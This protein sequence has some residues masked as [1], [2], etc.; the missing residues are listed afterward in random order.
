VRVRISFVW[1]PGAGC[2]STWMHSER[3][4]QLANGSGAVAGSSACTLFSSKDWRVGEGAM[5][6]ARKQ[7][8]SMSVDDYHWRYLYDAAAHGFPDVRSEGKAIAHEQRERPGGLHAL[9]VPTDHILSTA[10]WV[11]RTV[12][13][14]AE[15]AAEDRAARAERAWRTTSSAREREPAPRFIVANLDGVSDVDKARN[16]SRRA[17]RAGVSLLTFG[18]GD[19]PSLPV[20]LSVTPAAERHHSG[21]ALRLARALRDVGLFYDAPKNIHTREP[22]TQ[23]VAAQVLMAALL[24]NA[25]HA[26]EV[27]RG[28]LPN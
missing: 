12:G 9:V 26:P 16:F 20:W 4:V 18:V 2:E 8:A 3:L 11:D 21:E 28:A 25:S 22:Y 23:M 6:A 15:L 7:I 24:P 19:L 27:V 5:E 17:L 10:S 13:L 14:M 1:S